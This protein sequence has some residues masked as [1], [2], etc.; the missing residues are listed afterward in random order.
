MQGMGVGGEDCPFEF[1]F[2]PAT[3]KVGDSVS[4]RVTG[5]LADFPFAGNLVEVHRDYVIIAGD[6]GDPSVLYRGTRESRPVVDESE[7]KA[8]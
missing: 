6:A 8:A 4:F 1:N 7:I 5:S 2:D 3:F